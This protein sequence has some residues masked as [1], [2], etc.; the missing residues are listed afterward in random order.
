MVP[1][2]PP[3]NPPP[4]KIICQLFAKKNLICQ[5]FAKKN[6]S[7]YISSGKYP[8]AMHLICKLLSQQRQSKSKPKNTLTKPKPKPKEPKPKKTK[9]IDFGFCFF[10]F[11]WF[12]FFLVLVWGSLMSQCSLF[13]LVLAFLVLFFGVLVWGSLMGPRLLGK[14]FRKNTLH[15]RPLVSTISLRKRLSQKYFRQFWRP[16]SSKGK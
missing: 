3:Q 13:F 8:L 7:Q 10:V 4:K 15:Y 9:K 5:L 12:C 1:R 14:Y 2:P 11:F 16:D 6:Q